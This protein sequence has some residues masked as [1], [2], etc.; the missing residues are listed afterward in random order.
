MSQT[1]ENTGSAD[2]TPKKKKAL[3]PILVGMLGACLLG[4]GGFYMVYSGLILSAG[5]TAEGS[6]VAPQNRPAPTYMMIEQLTLSLATPGPSQHLRLS[7]HIEIAEGRLT[8]AELFRP[9]FLS[10][11]NTYLR[12][13]D[14][15]DLED[16]TALLRLRAQLL[17]RLQMVAGED[18]VNDFL[19]TEFI[20]N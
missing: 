4:G 13:I 7:A 18:L 17:R 8:D 6:S 10:V 16:P 12:A 5:N 3:L 20:L 19:I 2:E 1:A 11:I 14:P 15:S 9:R